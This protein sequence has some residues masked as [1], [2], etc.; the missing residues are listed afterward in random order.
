M[1]VFRVHWTQPLHGTYLWVFVVTL[2]THEISNKCFILVH[3]G[4]ADP[5]GEKIQSCRKL[6]PS[7]CVGHGKP[8]ASAVIHLG[9]GGTTSLGH[10][11]RSE[12]CPVQVRLVDTHIFHLGF[13]LT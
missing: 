10:E 1:P 9:M 11:H 12:Q 13:S 7:S 2:P 6:Q 3:F 4:Q 5:G 8:L